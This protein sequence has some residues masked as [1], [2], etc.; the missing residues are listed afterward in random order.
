MLFKIFG[1]MLLMLIALF[2]IFSLVNNY[3]KYGDDARC[4]SEYNSLRGNH[5]PEE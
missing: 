1:S 3:I 4:F 2:I 5:C